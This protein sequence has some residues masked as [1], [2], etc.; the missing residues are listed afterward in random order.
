MRTLFFTLA[1]LLLALP[2]TGLALEY[3]SATTAALATNDTGFAGT[4]ATSLIATIVTAVFG[5]LG[6]IFFGLMVYAGLLWMTA[7]GNVDAVKKAKSILL[8]AVVGLIIVLSSATIS[9]TVLRYL[10][11]NAY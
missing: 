6:V 10:G 11:S 1:A 8:N 9:F 2:T 5:I 3:D 4:S 7:G